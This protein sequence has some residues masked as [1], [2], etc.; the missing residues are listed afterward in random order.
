MK[1]L[2][3]HWIKTNLF[4]KKVL[5]LKLKLFYDEKVLDILLLFL[6]NFY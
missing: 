4:L 1:S 6:D 2:K 5:K 3:C